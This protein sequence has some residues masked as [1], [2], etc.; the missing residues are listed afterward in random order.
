MLSSQRVINCPNSECDHPFNS[1]GDA[2]CDRCHTPLIYRYLWATGN[3]A[4]EIPPGTKVA[5]RYEVIKPQIW[6][7]TQPALLP[8]IPAQLPN[9]VIPYLRSYSEYLHIPQAYGFTALAEAE[10]DILLLENAPIDETGCIYPTISDSWQQASPVRQVYWLWQILQLWTHLSEL[11]VAQSLLL[12][13]NLCVQGWC[14]RLLELHQTIEAPT[15]QDLGNFWRNWVTVAK[16]TISPKLASI[17]ELMCESEVNLEIINTQLNQLLLTTAAELPLYLTIAGATDTGL[18]IK[19]NED[20]CY[21]SHPRDIDDQLQ[22]R[23]SIICDGIGGH[24]GGEVASQLAL[25]SLKLQMRALLAE[26]GEQTELLTPDLLYQQIESCLRVINNVVWSRNDEQK[27]QGKERMAT[28]LVMSLQ[29]PQKVVTS[30][31]EELENAHE[32][33]VAHIGDSRAYWIT[34]NYCQ[35]LTVDDDMVKREVGLGKSLYRQALQIP[36]AKALTQA[37]GTKEAEFLNFSIQRF[38]IEEDGILL[39]CSDGLSDRNLVEQSW[40]DYAIPVLTGDLDI[41][42]ATQELI[43][44]ANEK[45]GQDNIS[46]ILTLC[47]VAKPSSMAIIPSPPAEIIP[48]QPLA[49][50]DAESLIIAAPTEAT[51]TESSQA[52][53]DLNLTEEPIAPIKPSKGKG[54]VLFAGLLVLL[55]GS[56]TIGLFAWWQLSP[57]SFLQVC[58]QLPQKVREFCPGRE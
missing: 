7:D 16:I 50:A 21:P 22:P 2:I 36:E 15:L 40:Q 43:K 38:I 10:G 17:V 12:A 6:L 30:A 31:G 29:I 51:L 52:L 56:S 47:R 25:Q 44:L 49:V 42:D 37:L 46:V 27:R 18:V 8:N 3:Q 45:N 24:E 9:I 39:L 48:P 20:A 1:V 53:L 55:L 35:L 34:Q 57:Q 5:D 23:L 19:H 26:I 54:L 58:R 4:A 14:I 41:E 32:L 13:D 11:G 33:Y 28:T